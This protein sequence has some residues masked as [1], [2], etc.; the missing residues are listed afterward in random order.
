M[1]Q[2]VTTRFKAESV[3]APLHVERVRLLGCCVPGCRRT[4]IHAHHAR[5]K[6]A[7]GDLPEMLSNVCWWHHAEWHNSGRFTWQA[8]HGIDLE[9]LAAHHAEVSRGLGILR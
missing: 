8:R 1:S 3:S 7:H 5:T 4:P 6:G 9:A 2:D